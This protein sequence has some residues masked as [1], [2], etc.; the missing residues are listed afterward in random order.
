[1]A[2]LPEIT[3]T[4]DDI[5]LKKPDIDKNV[6]QSQ[7]SFDDLIAEAKR[8]VYHKI[9]ESYRANNPAYDHATITANLL[10][11]KDYPD[12]D[13]IKNKIILL[14]IALV[15][16]ENELYEDYDVWYEQYKA[17]P[18][19]YFVDADSDSVADETEEK[20]V[21]RIKGFTR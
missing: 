13:N 20:T 16:R 18:L 19:D 10:L 12:E 21:S 11:V 3:V 17:A 9:K 15:F 5:K 4:E 6:S 7:L 14:V 2:L 8:Q 1:M